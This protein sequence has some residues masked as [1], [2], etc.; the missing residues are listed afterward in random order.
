[1]LAAELFSFPVSVDDASCFYQ[2]DSPLWSPSQAHPLRMVR[3]LNLLPLPWTQWLWAFASA[4]VSG[5]HLQCPLTSSSPTLVSATTV[6]RDEYG[7]HPLRYS[8][9][10]VG[11]SSASSLASSRGLFLNHQVY[12]PVTWL[13]SFGFLKPKFYQLVLA[14]HSPLSPAPTPA[15]QPVFHKVFSAGSPSCSGSKCWVSCGSPFS[16]LPAHC[17][18]G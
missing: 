7:P 3:A 9:C 1:M 13:S 6:W 15:P 14:P 12:F 18:L 5:F 8:C 2:R 11:S 17:L 10:F 16:S 4:L